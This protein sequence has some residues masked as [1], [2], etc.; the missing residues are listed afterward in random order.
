MNIKDYL[1]ST[2]LKT[3]SQAG[4]NEIENELVTK[5]FIQEAIDEKFKLIMIR[6]DRVALA[7][8]MINESHSKVLI[9]T[10]IDFPLGNS[11]IQTKL[12]EALQCI[13]NGADELDYV[14]NYEAFKA[15]DNTF[16]KEEILKGTQLGLSHKKV[17]KW[18]IE[19]AALNELQIAQLSALIKNVVVTHFKESDYNNVFVKSSTGFYVTQNNIP[20]GATVPAIKIMLENAAP[21][22]VKA[23]GGV[24]T[25][26]EAIDMVA[27]G[28]KRIGTSGAKAIANGGKTASQY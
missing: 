8:R 23:A 18:I 12:D 19:V 28:V 13:H 1:D 14:C 5:E 3:N 27:L 9:G 2:Y 10:V 11:S 25:Y 20:N 22:P 26:D 21:L 16:V 4:K 17:V 7:K 24:R 6:P 15:G